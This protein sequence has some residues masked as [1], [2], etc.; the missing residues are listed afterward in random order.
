ML[1]YR[2]NGRRRVG[3]PW[4]RL[5]D[6]ATTDLL[7][8]DDDDDCPL[9]LTVYMWR[10]QTELHYVPVLWVRTPPLKQ[11]FL[12][13]KQLK[14]R[15]KTA[16]NCSHTVKNSEFTH[17]YSSLEG[18][19]KP[20]IPRQTWTGPAGSR[21]LRLPEFLD[22]RHMKAARLSAIRTGRLYPQGITLVLT[23][24]IGWVG[25]RAI[26]RPGGLS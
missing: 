20:V 5:L 12:G 21:R 7:T 14:K 11:L 17:H 9:P 26:V 1:N 6:E 18:K 8:D 19:V 24:V 13:S 4:K 15:N 23:S 22:S 25:P 3:R 2:P 10:F 16:A